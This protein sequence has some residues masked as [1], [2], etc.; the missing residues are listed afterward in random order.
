MR[1]GRIPVGHYLNALFAPKS[2][3]IIGVSASSRRSGNVFLD[4]LRKNGFEGRAYAVGRNGGVVD[5]EQIYRSV[6]D[7]PEVPDLVFGAV[8]AQATPQAMIDAAKAGVQ[9]GIVFTAGFA[10]MSSDG[11]EVQRDMVARC[12]ELGMRVV[13]PNCMGVFSTGSRMNLTDVE[14]L[15]PGPIGFASQSGNIALSVFDVAK[16]HDLGF[17]TFVSFGNQADIPV[18]DYVEHMAQDDAVE[19]ILLY[20]E[21]LQENVG[22]DFIA[23]C[24][25][26]AARKPIVAIKGGVTD[27][28][29]RAAASHTSRLSAA[30]DIYDAAFEQAGIVQVRDLDHV[31]A[32]VEAL[33]RCPP[34]KGGNVA[35]VGSGGG[36]STVGTDAVERAGLTVPA[37]DQELKDTFGGYLPPWAPMSNPVDMTGGF[38][39]DLTL[40]QTLMRYPLS[41]P[42]FHGGLSYGLYGEGWR[43][44][45]VDDNGLT[46][47]TAAPLFA[48]LQREL[49]K[50]IVFYTPFAK[51]FEESFSEMRRSGVPCYGSLAEAAAGLA[52]LQKRGAFLARLDGLQRTEPDPRQPGAG[53]GF[54][55]TEHESLQK[56]AA[57]GVPA[58]RQ[59]LVS[60]AEEAVAAADAMGYPVVLK[61]QL[62]DVAHKSDV[63]G[64]RLGLTTADEVAAAFQQMSSIPGAGGAVDCTVS[65]QITGDR[66]L[67]LGIR[68]DVTFGHTVVIGVGGVLTE[69][70]ARVAVLIPPL[71]AAEFAAAIE[72]SP[73]AA[74]LGAWRGRPAVDLQE[75]H[76]QVTAL[77]EMCR[78]DES[79]ESV[80][81]NPLMA[82]G[83]DLRAAD[84]AVVLESEP[85]RGVHD[86]R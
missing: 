10:E 55:L 67:L 62:T 41:K 81:I 19:I 44:G 58:V 11:A 13:G 72:R 86:V 56:I 78:A 27:A 14:S 21:S 2:V 30:E 82:V 37:F 74:Y 4:R 54:T 61:A 84:A 1:T 42:E 45:L 77:H 6:A 20:L 28:G 68:K 15:D 79:V 3:A 69:V 52:A 66:E 40:F 51:D 36:H 73:V 50:P 23:R 24:R 16:R 39:E 47:R 76:R 48:A 38:T 18:A 33:L 65:Q 59:E 83:S 49:G 31:V 70:A 8:G 85:A 17:Q 34:M 32:V 29:R 25:A 9:V 5:G 64:V 53:S 22:P 35:I 46:F 75:L 71:D 12:N 43:P 57:A 80:D 63:N 26:V 60:S 7:L